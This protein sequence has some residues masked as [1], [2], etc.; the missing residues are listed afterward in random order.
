MNFRSVPGTDWSGNFNPDAFNDWLAI[1]KK[2][3][4]E[5]DRYEVAMQFAGQ[6]ISYAPMRDKVLMHETMIVALN[7]ADAEEMRKGYILGVINQRGAHFVDP[8]GNEER[9]IADEYK[10]ASDEA[11]AMGYLRYSHALRKIADN[12]EREAQ[13]TVKEEEERKQQ[14]EE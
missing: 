7:D 9:A 2:W 10:K 6:G 12:Y 5:N 1:V 8:T 13:Q 3:A 14:E 4:K 11:L